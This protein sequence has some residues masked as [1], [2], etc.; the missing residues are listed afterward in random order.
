MEENA[1]FMLDEFRV[2]KCGF[3][4]YEDILSQNIWTCFHILHR[5]GKD[6]LRIFG[7]ILGTSVITDD[8]LIILVKTAMNGGLLVKAA[9]IFSTNPCRFRWPNKKGP[10]KMGYTCGFTPLKIR[11][12]MGLWHNFSLFSKEFLAALF[13]KVYGRQLWEICE[14]PIY[15]VGKMAFLG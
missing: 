6:V 14:L 2:G 3:D 9:T 11:W 13:V 8:C 12:H 5:F 15:Y 10:I 4:I 1:R 7:K